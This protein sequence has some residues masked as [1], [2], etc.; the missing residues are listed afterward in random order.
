MYEGAE[1][2]GFCLFCQDL[3]SQNIQIMFKI[4]LTDSKKACH[5][6]MMTLPPMILLAGFPRIMA[7]RANSV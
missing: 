7:G 6:R 5:F 3:Q 2:T 4:P 1:I